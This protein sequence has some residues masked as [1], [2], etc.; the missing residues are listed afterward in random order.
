MA[1][2]EHR[3]DTGVPEPPVKDFEVLETIDGVRAVA[4]ATRLQMVHLLARTPSTGSML[5]RTLQIPANRAHYHLQ[6]LLEAG[7][8]RDVSGPREQRTEERYFAA[9]AR[10]LLVDPRLGGVD[11]RPTTALRQS[12]E[13]TFLDWRRSQILDIDWGDLARL[14]VS[15]ALRVQQND[16][17]LILFA[18]MALDLAEAILVEVEARGAIAHPRPWSRNV[19]LR[20]IDRYTSDDLEG[21]PFLPAAIDE[22]ITAAVLLT[23][24]LVQGAPPNA[25]QQERLPHYL[26]S[27]SSWKQ[28]V[29]RRGLRYVNVGLPHRGEFG[30]GYLSPEAGIDVFWRAVNADLEQIRTRGERLVQIVRDEPELI[31]TREDGSEFRVTVDRG[32]AGFSDGIISAEDLRAG[33]STESLPAG[34]FGALPAAGNG[35]GVFEADYIFANGRHVPHVRVVLQKG[36]VVELDAPTDA[37]AIRARLA[38]EAGDPDLL[39]SVT[40][41]LNPGGAGPTGRPE[42]D[43]VL[44]G[45]VTLNFGNNEIWG[46]NVKSTFNLCLP[47]HG[48][49]VRTES[50]SLVLRGRLVETKGPNSVSG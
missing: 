38:R 49:T 36:R 42:L 30:H 48:L 40:I 27:V 32:N 18:P 47:A 50:T 28:S 15:R 45:T 35:D 13:T 16:E 37:E 31:I 2:S 41:G 29:P 4:D 34:S 10:Y 3:D 20:T 26:Q 6:R 21:R 22:R 11:D 43:T 7:L 5:A 14:V 39:S 8:I 1:D 24:T 9:T 19:V 46:G 25:A 44:A 23:S 17:V 33:R 12:I